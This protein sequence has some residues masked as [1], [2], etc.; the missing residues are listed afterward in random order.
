MVK[1]EFKQCRFI[2][3]AVKPAG[4]PLIKSPKGIPLPEI[5][6]AGRSNVGKSSLINHL[7]AV[8]GL[9]KTSSTPG[10]TQLLNFFEVDER[11]IFADLP[12]YG[13]ARVP[14][15][16]RAEWGPMV[17]SYLD[18]RDNLELIIFLIDIRR[19]PNDEDLLFADWVAAAGKKLI[20]VLTKVDKVTTNQRNANALLINK[21]FPTHTV[22][23][24]LS[25]SVT[26]NI[27]RRELIAA[28]QQALEP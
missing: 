26:K 1:L 16:V 2:K 10:K 4:Y 12:G 7:F 8:K 17:Q 28:I 27:G 18:T 13:Y 15:K 9:A 6:V 23:S 5:A 25:Y 21:A 20:L 22:H 19:E 11:V 24:T 3:S 14:D